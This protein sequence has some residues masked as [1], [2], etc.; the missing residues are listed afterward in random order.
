MGI[1]VDIKKL[2][3]WAKIGIAVG[4]VVFILNRPTSS[5]EWAAW[6][7]AFGVIAGIGIAIWVPSH[8]SEIQKKDKLLQDQYMKAESLDLAINAA[9]LIGSYIDT[10]Q[11]L[12][13]SGVY[14]SVSD[15]IDLISGRLR[16]E[17][18]IA[19]LDGLDNHHLVGGEAAMQ[20][21]D[22]KGCALDIHAIMTVLSEQFPDLIDV[23][24]IDKKMVCYPALISGI[25]NKLVSLRSEL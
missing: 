2:S 23:S 22:L 12:M 11:G 13:H 7:Q 21:K 4:L 8:A 24:K 3:C 25:H 9:A 14:G 10:L 6:V 19:T 16:L 15:K 5:S 1:K 17:D 18:I 20:M